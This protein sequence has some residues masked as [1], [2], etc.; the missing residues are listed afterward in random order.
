MITTSKI[1]DE[2][3]VC[4][5]KL[6]QSYSCTRWYLISYVISAAAFTI[7]LLLKEL[8]NERHLFKRNSKTKDNIHSTIV[9][10]VITTRQGPV[11]T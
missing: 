7:N 4:E 3:Q 9:N 10:F 6:N 8:F 1:K 5:T 11:S 2:K